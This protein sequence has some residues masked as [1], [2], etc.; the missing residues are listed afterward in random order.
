MNPAK[1]VTET[2]DN[3][4][5]KYPPDAT[6]VEPCER[7]TVCLDIW[8]NNRSDQEPRNHEKYIHADETAA[9]A[10]YVSVKKDNRDD[11]YGPETV[12]IGAIS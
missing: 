11:C 3:E 10:R 7:K 8:Q 1:T 5:R 2:I 12:D 4:S 6:L 9:E